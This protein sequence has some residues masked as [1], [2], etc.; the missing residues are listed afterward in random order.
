[1]TNLDIISGGGG[2]SNN[3]SCNEALVSAE[4][5]INTIEPQLVDPES[6]DFRPVKGGNVYDV[7]TYSIPAFAGGDRPSTPLSPAG[8]LTNNVTLDYSRITR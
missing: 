1:M 4:N 5:T 2:D 7:T 3:P 6:G 8:N